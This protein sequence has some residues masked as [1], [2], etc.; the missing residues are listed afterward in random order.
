MDTYPKYSKQSNTGI[1]TIILHWVL[2]NFISTM[3]Y[4]KI[5]LTFSNDND[6]DNDDNKLDGC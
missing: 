3:S 5:K 1:Y 6:N 4:V 2:L